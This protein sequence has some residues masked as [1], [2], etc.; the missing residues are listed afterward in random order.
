MTPV[1]DAARARPV[2]VSLPFVR[3]LPTSALVLLLTCAAACGAGS[4]SRS[5]NPNGTS[6]DDEISALLNGNGLG[7]R[8]SKGSAGIGTPMIMGGVDTAQVRDVVSAHRGD[9]RDCVDDAEREG[10]T[11]TGR[12]TLRVSVAPSGTVESAT[13][14][15]GVPEVMLDCIAKSARTWKFPE[16]GSRWSFTYPYIIGTAAAESAVAVTPPMSEEDA[17]LAAL[18][19]EE[20]RR[21]EQEQSAR[22]RADEERRAQ[23]QAEERA[24]AAAVQKQKQQEEVRL[25]FSKLFQTDG[26]SS[27][28][29][30]TAADPAPTAILGGG[31][32]GELTGTLSSVIG[33]VERFP[34]LEAPREVTAGVEF[35]VEISLTTERMLPRDAVS[36]VSGASTEEGAIVMDLAEPAPGKTGW[37]LEIALS[38]PGFIVKNG[39]NTANV[40]LPK[41]G[42]STPAR[43]LL[44]AEAVSAVEERRIF[45]SFWHDATFLSKVATRVRVVPVGASGELVRAPEE[46]AA[47][48]RGAAAGPAKS[49]AAAPG[50]VEMEPEP[51]RAVSPTS[52][53][54]PGDLLSS[55]LTILVTRQELVIAS[56]HLVPPLRVHSLKAVDGLE[57]FLAHWYARFA[58]AVPRGAVPMGSTAAP[59]TPELARKT[60]IALLEGFGLEAWTRFAPEPVKDAYWAL[61]ERLGAKFQT[62]QV[63]TDAPNVPWELMRP[64][65]TAKGKREL[66]GFLAIERRVARWHIGDGSMQLARP[67]QEIA[68][69]G[70]TVIAPEYQGR[71]QLPSQKEE[72][73][74]LEGVT[75]Y[76]KTDGSLTAVE[77]MFRAEPG[78][79]VHFAGHGEVTVGGDGIPQYRVVLEDGPLDLMAWRGLAAGNFSQHPFFFFNACDVGR[80]EKVAGFVDGWAPA[81]LDAGAGGYVGG[82]WPLGD[83]AA[84]DFAR[85]FYT[86]LDAGFAE[87]KPVAVAEVL[88][89]ARK[90][91]YETGDPTYLAYV[92]YGDPQFRFQPPA[93]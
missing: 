47:R 85:H 3:R 56:P 1:R 89:E 78:G 11:I 33:S 7:G 5:A 77:S 12:V 31:G 64:S 13:A 9:V 42:D 2:A 39:A 61:H 63:V 18:E 55:D 60:N 17:R 62:V 34:T 70:V 80:A 40:H 68:F 79:I 16:S 81:A 71:A 36:V 45:A 65:R 88:C 52:G 22:Q 46:G 23:A 27:G 74:M 69:G 58:G 72:L 59:P 14:K 66:H 76:S 48:S 19:A 15:G 53:A 44:R 10:A 35:A 28:F 6:G 51:M 54:T 37:D 38:A 50:A 26:Y 84:A 90:R 20:R 41:S 93:E 32:G 91:F 4:A 43:F 21:H 25:K 73:A 92:F 83:R 30:D 57:P 49:V 8:P 29:D 67:P 87:G 75:G 24:R 86:T 82:L